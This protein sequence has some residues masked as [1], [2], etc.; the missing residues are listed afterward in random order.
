MDAAEARMWWYRALHLRLEDALPPLSGP[1]LDAGCG[2]GGMLAHLAAR[3]PD[4]ALVGLD[5]DAAAARRARA[6]SGAALA[7]GTVNAL[8]FAAASFA[9]VLS[10]DVLC[11][12]AVEP[13]A[14]LAEFARVLRPGGLLVLNMP[15]YGWMRSAHDRRVHNARRWSARQTRA[16]LEAAGFAQIRA[17]YWNSLL[18]PLMLAH[19]LLSVRSR[20]AGSDVVAFTP[21]VDASFFAATEAER[22]LPVALPAGGSVLAT[23]IRPPDRIRIPAA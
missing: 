15:A 16:A 6:K 4:L 17:R 18:F 9:A 12:A 7:R 8:P 3:R 2:T 10:A 22:R 5:Y 23:A 14:A 20:E 21:W 19:R 13:G 1:V 11:H